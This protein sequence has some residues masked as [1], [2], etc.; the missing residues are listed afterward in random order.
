MFELT[1]NMS[2]SEACD[3][4]LAGSYS[5]GSSLLGADTST[6][7]YVLLHGSYQILSIIHK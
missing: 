7:D 1:G 3:H 6:G 4:N 2:H 5:T